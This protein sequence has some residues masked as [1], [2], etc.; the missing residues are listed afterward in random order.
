LFVGF[1]LYALVLAI[2]AG[3][4]DV[5]SAL[6]WTAPIETDGV[7]LR[8]AYPKRLV[9]DGPGEARQALS[10]WLTCTNTVPSTPTQYVVALEPIASGV[11]FVDQDGK[12]SSPRLLITPTVQVA[13]PATLHLRQQALVEN[14]SSPVTLV[15]RLFDP[16]GRDL[17]PDGVQLTV[18]LETR[19]GAFW[20]HLGQRLLSPATPLLT[21][22]AGLVA[23]AVQEYRRA[24]ERRVE[25]E[26][27]ARE[28]ER[29]IA[30]QRLVAEQ[31]RIEEE[32]QAA[33]ESRL[34][35]MKRL[36]LLINQDLV[37]AV[38]RCWECYRKIETEPEWKSGELFD[39]LEKIIE[40][41]NNR[42][43]WYRI[44]GN[45][46]QDFAMGDDDQA[47]QL[48]RIIL[49]L[50]ESIPPEVKS[51]AQQLELV[52]RFSQEGHQLLKQD[53]D[54][55]SQVAQALVE[56]DEHYRQ[57][58][59]A[60]SLQAQV[61]KL[62][63][64]LVK[65]EHIHDLQVLKESNH[66]RQLLKAPAFLPPLQ[67]LAERDIQFAKILLSICKEPVKQLHLWPESRPVEPSGEVRT[68]LNAVGL[69]FNPFGP[70]DAKFDPKLPDYVSDEA[71]K[72]ARGPQPV[73]LFGDLGAGKSA[74]AL[75]IAHFESDA[76]PVLYQPVF[77]PP[78]PTNFSECLDAL[79]NA[80][81]RTLV[82]YLA[83]QPAGFLE[84]PHTR[85]VSVSTLLLLCIGSPDRVF[86]ELQRVA[87]P[88]PMH[89]Q[90]LNTVQSFKDGAP[91]L[92]DLSRQDWLDLIA[93]STPAGFKYTHILI[94]IEGTDQDT[95]ENSEFLSDVL[96]LMTPLA[97]RNVYLKLFI[98]SAWKERI[99]N[100]SRWNV[101]SLD[102]KDKHLKQMLNNRIDKANSAGSSDLMAL[103]GPDVAMDF[104]RRFIRAA[105]RSPRRM[106]Q[107]GNALL[108]SATRHLDSPPL[109]EKDLEDALLSMRTQ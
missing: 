1:A 7:R 27:E 91:S 88:N 34:A 54:A 40:E 73:L 83:S 104:E 108:A 31:K 109:T 85:Q 20:R 38:R 43:Q 51:R 103:C 2:Q 92:K 89:L 106:V 76:F 19:W 29:E 98:P 4:S 41:I 100:P 33:H 63:V 70:L 16:N 30:E 64:G 53:K 60:E 81:S 78:A 65:E 8:I 62:L 71:F 72:S 24:E 79:V 13:T 82:R 58:E 99:D 12:P 107:L 9:Q 47:L 56:V 57:V 11:A 97:N 22:A 45:A 26:K 105:R 55:V 3:R 75:T 66:G 86:Y 5:P 80:T 94:D 96:R 46:V 74:A 39:E 48:T 25:A 67:K 49:E 93:S 44:L 77:T 37:E 23:L 28:V 52:L 69:E 35:E 15:A 6:A 90:L 50:T 21:L 84:L 36:R 101:L 18:H 14:V 87:S 68:W 42:R 102:W 10:A 17:T 61:I 59:K 32:R 95:F